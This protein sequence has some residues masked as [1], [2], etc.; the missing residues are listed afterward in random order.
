[1]MLNIHQV[2][3]SRAMQFIVRYWKRVTQA[4]MNKLQRKITRPAM[5]AS[6]ILTDGNT[7]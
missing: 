3:A 1:M 4:D 7:L 5:N 2:I 6:S